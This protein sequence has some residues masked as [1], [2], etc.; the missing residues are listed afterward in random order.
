MQI[1]RYVYTDVVRVQ[2]IQ[3]HIDTGGIQT[4]TNNSAKVI[5]LRWRPHNFDRVITSCSDLGVPFL[6]C[7]Q[8]I[9]ELLNLQRE[10]RYK[11]IA[12]N[13]IKCLLKIDI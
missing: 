13:E 10:A 4:Y 7:R 2:D 12:W 9:D 1:R 8:R 5:F 3:E 6:Y 11:A